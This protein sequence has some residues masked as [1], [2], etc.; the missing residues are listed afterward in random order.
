MVCL[1]LVNKK[2][3]GDGEGKS[4]GMLA[5]S[6]FRDMH[7]F[8]CEMTLPCIRLATSRE[9]F[10]ETIEEKSESLQLYFL[11]IPSI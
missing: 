9:H 8:P 4:V 6:F 7:V 10:M 2:S 3:A 5:Y 11:I 1:I